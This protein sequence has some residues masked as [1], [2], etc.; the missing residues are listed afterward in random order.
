MKAVVWANYGQPDVLAL[1]DFH[2]PVLKGCEVLVNVKASTVTAGDVR[3]R[4]LDVP[5]GFEWLTRLAFGL[6]K[7]R[8]VIPGME[9]SGE[10][11]AIGEKVQNFSIGDRVFGSL[12]GRLGAH[13]EYICVP[14]SAV[15]IK[16]SDELTYYDAVSLVFGGQTA[17][18]FLCEKAQL[19]NGQSILINGAS[20][21]VGTASL[22]LAKYLGADVTAVCSTRN[23]EFVTSLGANSVI[24]YTQEDILNIGNAYDVVLDTVGNLPLSVCKHLLKPSGKLVNTNANLLTNLIALYDKQLI[25]GVAAESKDCL[26]F[27][28]Q[29]ASAGKMTPVIDRVCA[30]EKI[31]EAHRYVDSGRKRGAVVIA[32]A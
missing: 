26:E 11:V 2:K 30:L 1:S 6:L 24:D 21:A 17:F 4:A 12:G 5:R 22:Q 19:Q 29:L 10:I 18:Y 27:I 8:K 7:P 9:F 14:E 28:Q 3:L 23:V 31:V 25:C 15:I 32:M 20:G 13:A 16:K